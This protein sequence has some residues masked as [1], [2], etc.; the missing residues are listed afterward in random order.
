MTISLYSIHLKFDNQCLSGFLPEPARSLE[1]LKKFNEI[2]KDDNRLR[3]FLI[4]MVHP[5]CTCKKAEEYVV[6]EAVFKMFMF[7][8]LRSPFV[9]TLCIEKDSYMD[10]I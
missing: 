9:Q 8:K 7:F 1:Y 5:D 10:A 2:L 4:K 6:S 3:G